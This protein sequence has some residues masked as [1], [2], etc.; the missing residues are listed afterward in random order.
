MMPILEEKL[1]GLFDRV[2]IAHPR[3]LIFF[4]LSAVAA[5]GFFAKDF[6]IDA[7]ADTLVQEND[8]NLRY[9]QMIYSRY[10]IKDSLVIAYTPHADLLSDETL[11]RIKELRDEIQKIDNVESVTTLLDV[12]L[13][14][15]PKVSIQELTKGIRTLGSENV[16]RSLARVELANSPLYKNLLVSPDL[17]TTGILINFKTDTVFSELVAVRDRLRDKTGSGELTSNEASHYKRVMARLETTQDVASRDRHEDIVAIRCIM[18][19]YRA[20]ADLFLGGSSMIAD[21][22]I[23]FVKKD[24]KLFGAG[25]L[26]LLIFTL[27]IIFRKIRWVVLPMLCCIFSAITMIGI[28]GLFSWKVTVVSSN[29]ISLQIIISL[30]YTIHLVVRYRELQ[31]VN[32]GADQKTLVSGTVR[33][34]LIPTFYAALTTA[35]GFVS[36][37]F[38]DMPPIVTFGWMMTAGIC[39]SMVITFM[40]FPAALMLLK[41]LPLEDHK[42]I[43]IPFSPLLGRFTEFHKTTILTVSAVI[44]GLGAIG[45]SRLMVENSFINYFKESTEIYQGMKVIDQKLGGTTPLDV[46]INFKPQEMPVAGKPAE[47]ETDGDGFSDFSEFDQADDRKYWITPYK[48]DQVVQVDEYLDGLPE[49]GKVLSLGTLMKVAERLNDGKPLEAFE[50]SLVFNNFP[51][52]YKKLLVK[53]YVSIEN[54]QV[55]FFLRVRDSE[56]TLRR[57]TFLRAVYQDLTTRFGY[58]KEDVHL[59]GLLVLYNNMLQSLFK[60][61]ISSLGSAVFFMMCM[62]FVL[63]RSL[64]VSLIAI[65]PNLFSIAAVLGFMGWMKI[66]M[67]MMTITIASISISIAD[68]NTIHYIHRFREE[69]VKD[70]DYIG[71]M[72]RCH[73]SIGYDMFY[74]TV[75]LIIGFS[76]LA[77]SSFI[78]SIIFGLLTGLVMLIALFAALTLLPVVIILIK[79]FGPS[80]LLEKT[81]T[82]HLFPL[83]N[84]G[85]G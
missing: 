38:C 17:K 39:V 64:K 35:T 52:N 3:V 6:K 8:Q 84:G 36:L 34:M 61:Q 15:S 20:E 2:I 31:A 46:L 24:L 73:G 33:L 85:R 45:I 12:P 83:L 26:L 27:G 4:L 63:F 50:L 57:D 59:S 66:P 21:D 75:T 79:P 55:R 44:L 60:S 77:F 47:P 29:F 76:I 69:L 51:E 54:D 9:S 41:P 40:L 10:G 81:D 43:T 58:A 18:D 80:S 53:P 1:F 37:A 22:L 25:V 82:I 19:R 71:A 48:M 5:F 32:P 42:T 68:D 23:M 62:Y 11:R 74:T 72:H 30:T 7:S 13:L 65:F 67:D 49:S 78:P 28:L 16:D 56:P 70:F 14:E